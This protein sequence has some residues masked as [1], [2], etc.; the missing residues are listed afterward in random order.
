[1]LSKHPLMSASST[2]FGELDLHRRTPR[3]VERHAQNLASRATLLL[4][5]TESE[6]G[7]LLS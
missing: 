6:K 1:M 2:H 7:E 5:G 4:F 3:Q